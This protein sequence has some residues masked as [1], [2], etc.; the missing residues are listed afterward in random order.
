MHAGENC[1]EPGTTTEK[2][3]EQRMSLLTD[4]RPRA[5]AL[6][7]RPQILVGAGWRDATGATSSVIDPSTE[8]VVATIGEASVADMSAAVG[9]ARTAFDSGEWSSR[10][11]GERAEV[12]A[13][14]VEGL[15]AR[16]DELEQ[17]V[18]HENGAPQAFA[19]HFARSGRN[20]FDYFAKIAESFEFRT[21]RARADGAIS[22]IVK[23]PTGVVAAISPWNGALAV[24]GLK[25]GAALAAGCTTV[26]KPPPET[27]LASYVLGDVV[28][29]LVAQ[30]ALPEGVINIVP[31]GPE[32]SAALVADPRVDAVSFTGSTSVGRMI[33]AAAAD[34]IGR[35][36]L[37]LGGKSAAIVLGDMPMEQVLPSLVPAGCMN[38]GQACFG[39]TRVLV[40]RSRYDE[41]ADAMAA[42]YSQITVGSAHDPQTQ[43][44]PLTVARQLPRVQG[45][46]D[47]A[48]SEGASVK[49]GGGRPEHLDGKKGF[50]FAPTLLTGVRPDHRVAQ[51]EIFGP[52]TSLIAYDDLDDAVDIANSSIYGLSGAVYTSDPERGYEIARRV[53]TG[54]IA[55]NAFVFD[56]TMPFGGFKQ[57]GIGREGG[58][59]GIEDFTET[60]VVHM[61]RGV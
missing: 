20:H 29:D 56:I 34:R 47:A 5:N 44:G 39:L 46:V 37:E 1:A 9:A 8:E 53:R 3:K 42:A 25:L 22:R 48:V 52:V 35:V 6:N 43:M 28:A 32:S 36:T 27:P 55:V 50:Y 16:V 51:E 26:L 57:S 19:S 33:Y 59:E 23:E 24:A 11:P 30:G 41:Y 13:A 58:P 12:L 4:G 49:V 54:T 17:V 40:P 10:S 45:Y 15:D 7:D 2:R 31:A 60:K 61:P 18:A 38:S 14:I 21:D